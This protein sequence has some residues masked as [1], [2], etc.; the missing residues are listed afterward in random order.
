M[1]GG[2]NSAHFLRRIL[3]I[4]MTQISL[5]RRG[6]LIVVAL[7]LGLVLIQVALYRPLLALPGALRFIV[8]PVI[9]LAAGAGFAC[10]ATAVKSARLPDA[11]WPATA[12]GLG[13]GG[14]L[15]V[16]MVLENFGRHVGENGRLTLAFMG[17]T[18]ILWGIA[19]FVAARNTAS[20]P[21]GILAGC[22][23][24]VMSVLMA[25]SFGFGL[26]FFEVPSL[27]YIR[28]WEEFKQSGWGD[29]RAFGIA[30]SLEAG[31]THLV[32]GLL[33]GSLLGAI[34]SGVARVWWKSAATPSTVPDI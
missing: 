5:L 14:L 10:A 7:N 20:G 29:A 2:L 13:G 17:L 12:W 34:G 19:G 1:I 3:H 16:H 31:F 22:W 8:E 25:V 26:M 27:D 9:G 33:V 28:S 30:N 32:A 23:S 18:F 15:V 11:L 24:A 6:L 4:S 21:L